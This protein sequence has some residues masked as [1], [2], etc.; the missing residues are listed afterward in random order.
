MA[1]ILAPL[2]TAY[3]Y[4][5]KGIN[6]KESLLKEIIN[7]Q[8]HYPKRYFSLLCLNEICG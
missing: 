1:L 7:F 3:I 4:S 6:K 8:A 2:P 5:L